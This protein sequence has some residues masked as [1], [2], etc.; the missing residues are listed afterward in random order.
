MTDRLDIPA[1]DH[2]ALYVLTHEGRHDLAL[3][4][5]TMI[6]MLGP[7]MLNLDYVEL[8]AHA[9]RGPTTLPDLIR[10]GY[11]MP[12]TQDQAQT[13]STLSGHVLLIMSRA[14]DGVAQSLDLPRQTRL[15]IVLRDAP[16]PL[17]DGKITSEA[18]KG[19]LNGPPAKGKSDARMSGMVA[20]FALLV[21]FA[22]VALMVW[23]GR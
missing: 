17:Q 21:M 3:S 23:V 12:L 8:I 5:Q 20:T 10:Q 15:V 13:L 4:D 1:H 7:V 2:G 14:F 9:D 22:L 16:A 19:T 18:G 11:D 6:E